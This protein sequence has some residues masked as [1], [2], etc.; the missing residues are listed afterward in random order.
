MTHN[1]GETRNGIKYLV[2]LEQHRKLVDPDR[3]KLF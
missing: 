1:S 2:L 3:H